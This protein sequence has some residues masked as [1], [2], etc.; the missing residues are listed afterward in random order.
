MSWSCSSGIGLSAVCLRMRYPSQTGMLRA[1][2]GT[3]TLPHS[4][5]F[6]LTESPSPLTL[7][8][9][10]MYCRRL[11]KA[12]MS[13]CPSQAPCSCERDMGL[14]T[15][16][17]GRLHLGQEDTFSISPCLSWKL[18]GVTETFFG[19]TTGMKGTN[20]YSVPKTSSGWVV[21]VDLGDMWYLMFL[22]VLRG[23]FSTSWKTFSGSVLQDSTVLLVTTAT[24]YPLES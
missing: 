9:P 1:A 14:S 17:L 8:H 10:T 11:A 7:S 20:L 24:W 16:L 23:R 4:L 13:L 22:G 19:S 6:E 21:A 18:F 3:P 15:D 12:R 5:W 2:G